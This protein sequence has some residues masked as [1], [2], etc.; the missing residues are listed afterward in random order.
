MLFRANHYPYSTAVVTDSMRDVV[1]MGKMVKRP[2][3][4]AE[5]VFFSIKN[6]PG[7]TPENRRIF[8]I[9]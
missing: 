6:T 4:M 8:E 7:K 1:F 3:K 5:S 9:F 2:F